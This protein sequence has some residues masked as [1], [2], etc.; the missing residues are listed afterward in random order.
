[1]SMEFRVKEIDNGVWVPQFRGPNDHWRN[2][3]DKA[4]KPVRRNS[5][6]WARHWLQWEDGALIYA[7][8][9]VMNSE[10]FCFDI[11]GRRV[12]NDTGVEQAQ[13]QDGERKLLVCDCGDVSHQ[14]IIQSTVDGNVIVSVH[15]TQFPFWKRLAN[16]IRYI[17]GHRSKYGDFEEVILNKSH[18]TALQ[19]AV[20]VLNN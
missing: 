10:I 20:N 2:C 1:M 9:G 12:K 7:D 18:A 19:E 5:Y 4:G 6:S 13:K 14:L 17:F 15:L 8:K 11:N 3:L 16:G